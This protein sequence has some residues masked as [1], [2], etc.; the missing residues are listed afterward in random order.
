MEVIYL[1]LVPE[2]SSSNNLFSCNTCSSSGLEC[3]KLHLLFSVNYSENLWPSYLLLVCHAVHQ[4]CDIC[5]KE[6]AIYT[7]SRSLTDDAEFL[8]RFWCNRSRC[9]RRRSQGQPLVSSQWATSHIQTTHFWTQFTLGCQLLPRTKRH[10]VS[11]DNLCECQLIFIGLGRTEISYATCIP[12]QSVSKMVLIL[13]Y[14]E[15][16]PS[17]LC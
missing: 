8:S 13:R 7:Q 16:A 17:E 12:C 9:N 5:S 4:S 15:Y 10:F 6:Q 2:I 11:P 1:C 3:P 14:N